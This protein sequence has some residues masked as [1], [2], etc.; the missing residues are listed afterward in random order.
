MYDIIFSDYDGTLYG[1]DRRI[2]EKTRKSISKYIANGGKFVISTGRIYSSIK[3]IAKSLGLKD[4]IITSQ[5]SQIY[6]IE[7]DI[8]ICT[9][10]VDK[11]KT[12]EVLE[13]AKS[14]GCLA[15]CYANN[16]IFADKDEEFN[17][18]FRGFFGVDICLTDNLIEDI[19]LD[20]VVPNK[21]EMFVEEDKINGFIKDMQLAFP[22]FL[23]SKSA[24]VMIEVV[25]K[26][27]TKGKAV[28]YLLDRYHISMDDA[29]AIGDGNND[30]D[31]LQA[32][33]GKVAV[34][35][36]ATRLK[37]VADYITKDTNGDGVSE[38]IELVLSGKF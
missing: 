29:L 26:L 33:K 8:P 27:A 34:S 13:I 35:N 25:S 17:S 38:I 19:K 22:Q 12:I 6:N 10:L 20:K 11:Q 37:E 23:F 5:G 30:I 14:E 2:S 24:P 16:V 28:N 9:T 31:M 1:K 21:F 3:P 32:V 4:D 15:Q 36:G 18:F 7:E